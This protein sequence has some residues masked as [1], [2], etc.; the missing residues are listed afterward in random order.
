MVP[1]DQEKNIEVIRQYAKW[2]EGTVKDLNK[3]LDQYEESEARLKE[4][5][6]DNKL[7]DQLHR[8]QKKF[9]GFGREKTKGR[10]RQVGHQQQQLNIHTKRATEP[11]EDH[12]TGQEEVNPEKP[13]SSLVRE[14]TLTQEQMNEESDIRGIIVGEKQQAWSKVDGL[15]QESSEIAVTERIYKK[16]T[17][18]QAKYR[19]KDEFNNTDKEVI[20]TAP[21]PA[22]LKPGCKYSID[23]AIATVT[24]KYQYHLP[25]ERQ[26]R[27]MEESGL[28][29]SVKTLYRLC[30]TVAEH[31]SVVLAKIRREILDE[32]CAAHLDESPWRLF[33]DEKTGYMWVMSNRMGCYFQFEPTRSGRVP[34]E[35]LRGHE[36]SVV[37]D[38]YSGYN[39][40][41][42]NSKIRV[43]HCWSHVRREFIERLDDYPSQCE[44]AIA[45]IDELFAIEAQAKD[46]DG[47]RRLRKT[48][49]RQIVDTFRNWCFETLPKFL[50]DEGISEAI[51]YTLNHWKELTL[52][53]KD[54]S[55]P[56][57]NNEAERTIRH[58]VLGRK[59]F[60]GSKTIN[61][62]D[63]A[64]T[65]YTIIETCKRVS[66]HPADYLRYLVAERWYKRD[67][68]TPARFG[69][70]VQGFKKCADPW[71][72][73]SEWKIA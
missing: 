11:P 71:P 40:I 8:L 62:A 9:F 61:G 70:E 23:F 20:I 51:K 49:S 32:F 19:L 44:E 41:R 55:V 2:L 27:K 13:K 69:W 37:V 42:K 38:A 53:L 4:G 34:Q 57:S 56:I 65:L 12:G 5:W 68:L 29:V 63:T 59:N 48:R 15:Y 36:G 24:D 22:K 16:V 14:Y 64:A 35:M 47:L 50:D 52:F 67:P 43:G 73:K 60:N 31:G 25:L 33:D 66:V 17:H 6:L 3:K 46:F 54:V 28:N 39:P 72:A 21:G 18:R 30:E 26:R 10:H 1:I 58:P 45:L 7:R